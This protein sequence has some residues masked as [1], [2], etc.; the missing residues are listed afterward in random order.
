M[1]RITYEPPS[2]RRKSLGRLLCPPDHIYR[3]TY[4][5]EVVKEHAAFN[6]GDIRFWTSCGT[7]ISIEVRIDVI[8]WL[9]NEHINSQFVPPWHAF[10]TGSFPM[11]CLINSL[12]ATGSFGRE[13]QRSPGARLPNYLKQHENSC[14]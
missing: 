7:V 5:C 4:D 13:R 11:R 12:D 1:P 2:M 6:S 8:S 3:D 10:G 14:C 9:V